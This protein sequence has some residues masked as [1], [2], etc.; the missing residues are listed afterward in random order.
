MLLQ[1]LLI[2]L[3]VLFRRSLRLLELRAPMLMMV[4]MHRVEVR[5]EANLHTTFVRGRDRRVFKSR[6]FVNVMMLEYLHSCALVKKLRSLIV[7]DR[8]SFHDLIYDVACK[9]WI[10]RND[11]QLLV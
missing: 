8:L 6:I 5:P 3:V 4:T 1:L 7:R 2:L 10:P 11:H 9:A